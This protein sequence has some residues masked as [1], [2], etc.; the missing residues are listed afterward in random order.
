MRALIGVF[1]FF[2][3]GCQVHATQPAGAELTVTHLESKLNETVRQLKELTATVEAIRSEIARLKQQTPT[4]TAVASSESPRSTTAQTGERETT[5]AEFVT[6]LIDPTQGH[7]QR[8]ETLAAKPEMFV[9][10]RY[11]AFPIAGAAPEFDPN[12]TLSRI[13]TRWAGRVSDRLGAGI[14][15]QFHPAIDG[16]PEELVNDAFVEYYLTEGTTLRMGQ[17]IQPFGFEIQQSSAVREAPERGM[18]AGYF[19][20]GQ[21]DRGIMVFG[22]LGF[23]GRQSLRDVHYF[24]GAFNGNRFFADSNRQLNYVFRVRKLFDQ[25]KLAVGFSSQLGTQLLPAGMQGSNDEDRFGVDF[26][27]V[28]G[29]IGIRGELVAGN[30]PSTLLGIDSSFA[31]AFRPGA[32]SWGGYLFGDYRINGKADVYVRYDQFNRDPVTGRNV[33]AVSLGYVRHLGGVSRVGFDY[34]FKRRPTF[35]DDAVNS[36]LQ[37][38]WGIEF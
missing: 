34:Q 13:E 27:Y 36:R 10:T 35:N 8:G 30:T 7:S 37:L 20:P 28:L 2:L 6:R 12:F 19:F 26:Q 29:S 31:P 15:L 16:S 11:A 23:L 33:R 21:R 3:V 5:P 22:N 32:H 18:F 38:T 24:V 9:Q 14:E 4:T 17:F 25:P 1:F